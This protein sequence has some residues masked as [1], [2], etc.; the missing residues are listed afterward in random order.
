MNTLQILVNI[1]LMSV[2]LP[3]NVIFMYQTLIDL[4]K[5]NIIP[6]EKIKKYMK[7][8]FLQ[9]ND[10]NFSGN[11][12]AQMGSNFQTMGYESSNLLDNMGMLALVIVG[13]VIFAVVLILVFRF[14]AIKL[15]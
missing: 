9:K 6:K 4:T 12:T 5:F 2:N 11:K 3:A 10:D 13:L 15:Q 14:L 8:I 7:N 1:P